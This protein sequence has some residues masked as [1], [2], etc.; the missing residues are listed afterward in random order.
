MIAAGIGMFILAFQYDYDEM[1]C[2][3]APMGL[4]LI[5]IGIYFARNVFD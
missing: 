4:A 2:M 1:L 5:G 3:M